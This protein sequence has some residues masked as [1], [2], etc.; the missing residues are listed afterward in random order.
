[1][2]SEM[3]GSIL[4]AIPLSLQKLGLCMKL[5]DHVESNIISI[6]RG[7]MVGSR[8]DKHLSSQN[9]KALFQCALR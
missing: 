5:D 6:L 9:F 4:N 2:C 7:F 1:M 3:M 8:V